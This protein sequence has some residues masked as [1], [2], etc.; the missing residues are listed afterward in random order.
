MMGEGDPAL[1]AKIKNNILDNPAL[2]DWEKE[3][4]AE[5]Y[6]NKKIGLT[7][8][9]KTEDRVATSYLKSNPFNPFGKGQTTFTERIMGAIPKKGSV[10]D[11]ILDYGGAPARVAVG[12]GVKG[13]GA[14]TGMDV[15]NA[16]EVSQMSQNIEKAGETA[17]LAIPLAVGIGTSG[18]GLPLM[19]GASFAAGAAGQ[20]TEDLTD[21]ATDSQTKSPAGIAGSA[22][23]AGTVDTAL[24]LLTVGSFKLAKAGL[25]R[26]S[27]DT[28]VSDGIEKGIKPQYRG[29]MRNSPIALNEY[30]KKASDAVA[31]II[32]RKQNLEYFDD[33]GDLVSKGHAP[34]NLAEFAQAIDQ[35]KKQIYD[36]YSALS[37]KATQAGAKIDLS[38]IAEKLLAYAEDPV[39]QLADKSKTSY[40]RDMAVRLMK[41]G[42]LDPKQAEV[43]IAELNQ[44]LA[45]S[46][47]DKSVK[48][49][50]E[51]DGSIASALRESLDDIVMKST[52]EQYQTLKNAY[53]A[54]KTI[55]KDV[56]H[57]ALIVA[58]KNVKGLPE[59][60]DIFTGGDI[61][62]GLLTANPAMVTKGMV[63]KGISMY[64]RFLNSPDANIMKMFSGAEKVLGNLPASV[65]D[66]VV[67]TAVKSNVSSP[68]V[69][70][71]DLPPSGAGMADDL[72]KKFPNLTPEEIAS[73]TPEEKSLGA[74]GGS[75]SVEGVSKKGGASEFDSLVTPPSPAESFAETLTARADYGYDHSPTENGVPAFDLIQKVDGEQIIPKDMYTQWYGSRGDPADLESIA[76]LKKIKGKPEASVTIYRAA[77]KEQWNYGD[78]I[79]LSKKYAEQHAENNGFKVFSKQVKAKDLKWAMD[80]VNEFGYFPKDAKARLGQIRK[81]A[82]NKIIS[83]KPST[84]E[85][86]GWKTTDKM[87]K[88]LQNDLLNLDLKIYDEGMTERYT[89]D[90][91]EK[92]NE[93][94]SQ[95]TDLWKKANQ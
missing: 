89:G 63:G 31:E 33:S 80:D 83:Q 39:K 74:V 8:D 11:T 66:D 78:W 73:L 20:L 50:S 87:V 52:G 88:Q 55:E 4:S 71:L 58:R 41:K 32:T 65:S 91:V 53:G 95:L 44:G 93:T 76:A 75:D 40:A 42:T 82:N 12:M 86:L 21:Y 35:S 72:S 22:L 7:S 14:V 57:R 25:A 2:E 61:V 92:F 47:A 28:I 67:R 49:I 23:L 26:K 60:T 15:S 51:V 18:A 69:N 9:V 85:L 10:L 27:F 24:D 43:L 62:G 29:A 77:P 56:G 13:L 16:P 79:T 64:Y 90:L 36:Q 6:L 17:R 48:G 30:K 37:A 46:F 34:T 3:K 38:T 59:L 81:D 1:S 54:L 68:T 45:K 70:P 94:K 84:D 5:Y 19:A